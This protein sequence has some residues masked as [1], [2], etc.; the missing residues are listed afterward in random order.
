MVVMNFHIIENIFVNIWINSLTLH[1]H[2]SDWF[3]IV[4]DCLYLSLTIGKIFSK[5]GPGLYTKQNDLDHDLD[6]L[7]CDREDAPVLFTWTLIV[8]YN[9]A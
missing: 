3:Q 5:V 2:H 7:D 1:F 6:R 8:Q 9:N 4:C